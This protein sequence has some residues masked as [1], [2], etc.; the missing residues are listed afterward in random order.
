[1]VNGPRS[2]IEPHANNIATTAA[3]SSLKDPLYSVRSL[4]LSYTNVITR[5]EWKLIVIV[6]LLYKEWAASA[7]STAP[8]PTF[9]HSAA[10]RALRNKKPA[11]TLLIVLQLRLLELR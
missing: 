1:V 3:C 2:M 6:R 9:T 11:V 8:H 5:Y 7:L 10:G 4:C